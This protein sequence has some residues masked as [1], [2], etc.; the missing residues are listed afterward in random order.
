MAT[1][2]NRS[3]RSFQEWAESKGFFCPVSS[4]LMERSVDG[5]VSPLDE[6]VYTFTSPQ[7]AILYVTCDEKSRII[8]VDNSE[9]VIDEESVNGNT[10]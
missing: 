10:H 7:G 6:L 8:S 2:I 1:P 4:P 9:P 3:L 5:K